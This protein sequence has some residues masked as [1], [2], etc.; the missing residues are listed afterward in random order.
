MN[1][2]ENRTQRRDTKRGNR[3]YKRLRADKRLQHIYNA[4]RKRAEEVKQQ[5]TAANQQ[6]TTP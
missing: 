5:R 3:R 4:Q 1:S 6:P 2:E